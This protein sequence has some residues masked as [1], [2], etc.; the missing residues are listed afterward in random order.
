MVEFKTTN[1]TEKLQQQCYE[2]IFES[3]IG[4]YFNGIVLDE[5]EYTK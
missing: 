4:V 1:E 5:T 3:K 2:G